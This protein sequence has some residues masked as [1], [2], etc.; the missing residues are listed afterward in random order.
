MIATILWAFL[1]VSPPDSAAH[2]SLS[3][4]PPDSGAISLLDSVA[5][6]PPD[7][8]A[9]V[10]PEL[11]VDRARLLRDAR[12]RAPT[13]FVTEIAAGISNHALESI[14]DVLGQAAGVHIEQYGGLGAFSTVSLRGSPP[15]Q[16]SVY[17]DGAPLTSA[18][19]GV[20][21]L[22]D[23]PVTAIDH[24]EVYRGFAPVSLGPST[25]GGA[26]NLVTA[27]AAGLSDLHLA[28][29]SYDTWEGRASAGGARGAFS[30]L[31]HGGIQSSAG[32]FTY[33]NNHGTPQNP[34]DDFEQTRLNNRFD[35]AT[36]L[37]KLHW[38]PR[39]DLHAGLSEDFFR[40][41]QGLPGLGAIPAMNARLAFS[42]SITQL[43]LSR[44]ARGAMP[45]ATVGANLQRERS[46]FRDDGGPLGLGELRLGRHNTDDRFGAEHVNAELRWS[47]MPGALALSAS[48]SVGEQRATLV[49]PEDGYPDPPESRRGEA[50]MAGSVEFHPDRLPVL[51]HA[52]CRWDRFDD[53]LHAN[54]VASSQI[55]IDRVSWLDSPQLGARIQAPAGLELRANWGRAERAPD[56]LELFGNQGSVT[57]NPRLVPE[58]AENADAGVSWTAP[59]ASH[60]AAL[61]AAVFQSRV[62]DLILYWA[63]SPNTTHADNVSSALIRGL[64]VSGRARPLTRVS[65]SA[66]ATWQ[67]ATDTGPVK[68][69]NGKR[70]PQRPEREVYARADWT[71]R[72][73][74]LSAD[75]H[76]IGDNY[77]DRYNAQHVPSR[78]L[79]GGSISLPL[80]GG[81]RATFEAKNLGDERAEDVAGYP[82]PGRTLFASLGWNLKGD[83]P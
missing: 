44:D 46:Q 28:H 51:L 49:D 81:V 80:G 11:R 67:T 76:L 39:S 47:E 17:L 29:G 12:R 10:L 41:A 19:H 65:L 26:I 15:G 8:I 13:A 53:Q 43:D 20:V 33:L 31:L 72:L 77:R 37:G 78:T 45:S 63:N 9:V 64:E 36:A 6:V 58:R 71:P 55:A 74:R 57:G 4:A 16:V 56:F 82:L 18:A 48:G 60:A 3:A 52:A 62:D 75:A 23:L 70:L 2:G 1:A 21:N 14:S 42:R 27:P 30:G 59:A 25:P 61:E 66:S 40:K 24:V 38:T 35:A 5:V 79:V 68:A 83:A 50:G 7:S 73:V 22:A 34:N 32:D 69:W 54:G